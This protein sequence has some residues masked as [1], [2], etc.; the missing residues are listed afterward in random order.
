[1]KN[2]QLSILSMLVSGGLLACGSSSRPSASGTGNVSSEGT[3]GG[4]SEGGD[5]AVDVP[6]EPDAGSEPT[7][8][9]AWRGHYYSWRNTSGFGVEFEHIP[10]LAALNTVEFLEGDRVELRAEFCSK[11]A[12]PRTYAL[13]PTADGAWELVP[14]AGEGSFIGFSS[15]RRLRMEEGEA[16]DELVLLYLHEDGDERQLTM[17]KGHLCWN[18]KCEVDPDRYSDPNMVVSE[19][20]FCTSPPEPCDSSSPAQGGGQDR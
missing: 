6:S 3:D 9:E 12:P 15:V 10:G 11:D 4:E 16:C 1:M 5:V 2:I 7:P 19:I 8:P 17:T 14:E 20:D 18:V 13:E